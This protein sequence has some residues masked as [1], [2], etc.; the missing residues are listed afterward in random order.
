[1]NLPSDRGAQL[2]VETMNAFAATGGGV[3]PFGFRSRM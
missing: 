3:G 2:G 1:M